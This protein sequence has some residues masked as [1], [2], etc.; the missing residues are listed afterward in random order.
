MKEK[1]KKGVNIA[2]GI[3]TAL[4]VAFTV[5]MLVF[6]I[7][8]VATTRGNASLFGYKAYIVQ[9]D[10]MSGVFEAGDVIV[11]KTPGDVTALNEGDIITFI[12]EDPDSFG[13][14]V[15]HKIRSVEKRGGET[16]YH[17]YGVAN[18]FDD[19]T[20]VPAGNVLGVYEFRIAGLGNFFAFIRTP[21]G[22][23]VLILLPFVLLIALN[24][25]KLIKSI[26]QYRSEKRAEREELA[27][28]QRLERERIAEQARADREEVERLK[29]ELRRLKERPDREGGPN[30][31]E[32]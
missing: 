14:I 29:E 13:A 18:G 4:I 21:A 12:S 25:G 32:Q 10:S 24:V 5:C 27:A 8:S 1:T 19:L 22:Y 9:S 31:S 28:Q 7:V 20:P 2:L 26:G 11:V 17:T 16:L 15:T 6:T 30:D 3:L 23:V